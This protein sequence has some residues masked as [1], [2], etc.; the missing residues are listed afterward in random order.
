MSKRVIGVGIVLLMLIV[1]TVTAFERNSRLYALNELDVEKN[2]AVLLRTNKCKGCYLA[3]AKLS[4]ADLAYADLRRAN[5]IGTT[6]IRATLYG[7][8]LSGAKTAGANF[9]GA[10]WIDGSICLPGSIGKCVRQSQ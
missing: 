9:S 2:R 4:G 8:D 6:F 7:A 5:L 3:Y 10:Q 1:T